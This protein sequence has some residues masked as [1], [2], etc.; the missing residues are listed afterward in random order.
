MGNGVPK[1]IIFLD[2]DGVLAR[3]TYACARLFG[4]D[5]ELLMARWV[6]GTYDVSL[7]LGVK[8][9]EEMWKRI[10]AAGYEFWRDLEKFPWADDLWDLCTSFASQVHISTSPSRIGVCTHGKMEWLQNW[11][12]KDFRN[13][14]IGP[15]KHLLAGPN[16]I[17][18][19]DSDRKIKAFRK[20]GGTGILFPQVWNSNHELA[21]DP[22]AYVRE[23]LKK[24]AS[25]EKVSA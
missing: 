5:W 4:V 15:R 17:L 21:G 12:G 11:R 1:V 3:F 2:M 7:L 20:W 6:P 9:E 24:F 18:I 25:A 8:D 13:F 23:E 10:H 19:D 16:R 22:M 14:M